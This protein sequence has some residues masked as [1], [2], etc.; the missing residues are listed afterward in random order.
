VRKVRKRRRRRR[1]VGRSGIAIGIVCLD[2]VPGE[3]FAGMDL[4]S[5]DFESSV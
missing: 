3:G 1:S 4:C 5:D 2:A